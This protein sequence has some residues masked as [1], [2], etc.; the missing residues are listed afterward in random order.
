MTIRYSAASREDLRSLRAYLVGE[1]GAAVADKAVR[2]IITDISS[3]KD[4]PGLLRP[5]ANKIRRPTEYDYFL[6]GRY[7]IAISLREKN[8]ISVLRILDGRT[9]Y[10]V[11][12]FGPTTTR[13]RDSRRR[14]R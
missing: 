8:V 12:V 13:A 10:A 9:D 6:C 3:L 4:N 5:L 7:S 11:E 1:F 14:G 2:K